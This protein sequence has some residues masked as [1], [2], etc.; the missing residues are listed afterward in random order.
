MEKNSTV[1]LEIT[2]VWKRGDWHIQRDH[3][4]LALCDSDNISSSTSSAQL[5]RL[6]DSVLI[7]FELTDITTLVLSWK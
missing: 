5:K 1:S 4:T 7:E 3:E 6:D 2:N